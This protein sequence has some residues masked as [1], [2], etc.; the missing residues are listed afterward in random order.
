VDRSDV[1][2][3]DL[4]RLDTVGQAPGLDRILIQQPLNRLAGR[5]LGRSAEMRLELEAVKGGRIMAGRDHH[6][7]NRMLVLDRVGHRRCRRRAGC[8]DDRKT[9]AGKDLSGAAAKCV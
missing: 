2:D 9:V 7:A 1:P 8:Q 6:A 4:P 3:P 5:G